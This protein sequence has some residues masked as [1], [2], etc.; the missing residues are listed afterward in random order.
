M[1]EVAGPGSVVVPVYFHIIRPG[2]GSGDIPDRFL[3]AQL[4]VMNLAY[5]G[6]DQYSFQTGQG[7]SAQATAN[8]PF[9]FSFAGVDRTNNTSWYTAS[10][11][12]SAQ[13][14][15]KTALRIGGKEALNVY[16]ND[17]S[18]AGLLGYA[19]FPDSYTSNPKDDGVVIERN[20]V[21]GG[22]AVPYQF[23]DTLVHEVGHWLG[24]YHTFQGGC[25]TDA[26]TDG[27]VDTPAEST[28]FYGMPVASAPRDTCTAAT[29]PGRD[30][31]ENFMDYTD[32]DGLFQFTAGQSARMDAA[33]LA[34]RTP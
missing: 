8:T 30:P 13:T 24:L 4:K 15:M 28:A 10:L 18:A 1:P 16:L 29:Y 25:N 19:T 32:D 23:G 17:Q 9:R 3:Y 22:T 21:P 14:S 12:S 31:V 33:H 26:N 5:S 11:G 20:S 34:F 2:D 27:V 7:P 6:R